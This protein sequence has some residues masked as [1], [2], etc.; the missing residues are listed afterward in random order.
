[1][2]KQILIKTNIFFDPYQKKTASDK[3]SPTAFLLFACKQ[4]QSP[5][6]PLAI[7]YAT[8]CYGSC[9]RLTFS[10]LFTCF[11]ESALPLLSVHS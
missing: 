3:K 11:H 4:L 7:P 2:K 1:M 6:Q 5:M 10:M 8:A 9:S